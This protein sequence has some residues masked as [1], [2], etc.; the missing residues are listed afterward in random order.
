MRF[1]L[2]VF[3]ACRAVWPD[4]KPMGARISAIDWVDGGLTI[5]ET[6]EV[7]KAFKAAGCDFIDVTTAGLDPR[8]KITVG[9]GYQ[10]SFA[11]RIKEETGMAVMA[12][13]MIT[14]PGQAEE[15]VVRKVDMVRH[16]GMMDDPHWPACAQALGVETAYPDQYSA[17]ARTSG[18]PRPV[19][20]AK[21]T[22]CVRNSNAR[23]VMVKHARDA[24]VDQSTL[25]QAGKT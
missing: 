13:G 19:F 17:H 20:V 14:E 5:E 12:V 15:I 10:V 8:Q 22:C 9:P 16:R 7:A 11:E 21:K 3:G 23:R 24:F 4:D 1:P 6:V 25:T 2:E 18:E